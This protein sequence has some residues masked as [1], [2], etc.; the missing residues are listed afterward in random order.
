MDPDGRR[1]LLQWTS[2]L[3]AQQDANDL[4]ADMLPFFEFLR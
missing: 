4:F 1:Y 2:K 3:D